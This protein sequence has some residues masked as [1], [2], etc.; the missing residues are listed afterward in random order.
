MRAVF[1]I[2]PTGKIRAL[3]YYPLSNGRNFQEIK[4]LLEAMQTSDKHGVATPADWQPGD[5]V[6]VPTPATSPLAK[7]RVAKAG[8][9]YRT[10]DWFFSLK[11]LPKKKT[12]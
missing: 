12:G 6:I 4:R 11:K 7:E 1:F 5:D 8:K 2:D 9:D 3:I 10:C